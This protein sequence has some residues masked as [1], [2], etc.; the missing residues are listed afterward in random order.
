MEF[1]IA[2]GRGAFFLTAALCL[3]SCHPRQL[4][5][6]QLIE[7]NVEVVGGKAALEAIQSIRFDLHITDPGFDVDGSYVAARPGW[8]R[9]DR[10]LGVLG[11]NSKCGTPPA[12]D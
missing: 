11:S 5:V 1:F 4:T 12:K 10:T 7:R 2:V 8:M 6:D 3:A 9:I